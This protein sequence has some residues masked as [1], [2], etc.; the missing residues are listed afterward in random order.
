MTD[1]GLCKDTFL[2]SLFF[3]EIFASSLG[4]G[5]CRNG[6]T[7]AE[8]LLAFAGLAYASGKDILELANDRF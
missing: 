4:L 7:L 3:D 8:L 2:I 1:T 6:L 5:A